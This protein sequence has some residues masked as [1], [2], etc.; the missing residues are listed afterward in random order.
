M[1]PTQE[2]T[3]EPVPSLSLTAGSGLI[4]DGLYAHRLDTTK[5]QLLYWEHG[6]ATIR[7]YRE[8]Y[9]LVGESWTLPVEL[10]LKVYELCPNSEVTQ[11]RSP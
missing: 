9:G 6:T 2:T 7:T 10:F 4:L 8:P 1:K 11:M 3:G 5:V